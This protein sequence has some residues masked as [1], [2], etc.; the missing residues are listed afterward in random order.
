MNIFYPAHCLRGISDK[1]SLDEDG[2]PTGSLFQFSKDN[3]GDGFVE[4]SISWLDDDGVFDIIFLQKNKKDELQFKLGAVLLSK[5]KINQIMKINWIKNKLFYERQVI[6]DNK[7]HGNLLVNADTSKQ[8]RNS[9]SA[10]IALQASEYVI[11]NKY[12]K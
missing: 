12:F 7:Y 10:N 11:P 9:I 2:I 3:R 6:P 5:E 4:E 1:N 8:T